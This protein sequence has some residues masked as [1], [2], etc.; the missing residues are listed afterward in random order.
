M[1]EIIALLM[2]NE[3]LTVGETSPF[4]SSS[5][6]TTATLPIIRTSR[7]STVPKGFRFHN[8]GSDTNWL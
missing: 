4:H 2:D 6:E 5:Q 3:S 7:L 1:H 8:R